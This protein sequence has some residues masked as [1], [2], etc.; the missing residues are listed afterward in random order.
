MSK[1]SRRASSTAVLSTLSLLVGASA[2]AGH[3][4]A[5]SDP[6]GNGTNIPG[7]TGQYI[8]TIPDVCF[9]QPDG[10]YST[11]SGACGGATVY[12]GNVNLYSFATDTP[13]N[14]SVLG[15]FDLTSNPPDTWPIYDVYVVDNA[16]AGVDTGLMGPN[17]GMGA[18]YSS[19]MFWLEFSSGQSDPVPP[20]AFISLDD[21]DTFSQGGNMIFGPACTDLSNCT[22]TIP[23]PGSLGLLFAALGGGWLARRR[24]GNAAV[25]SP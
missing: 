22:V 3:Y 14:G 1:K 20:Q 11:S 19:D 7:F 10:L 25:K 16:L 2:Q 8:L 12:S 18:T 17:P 23:E 4:P 6:G 24:K 15:T 9:E 13:P 5:S 21:G